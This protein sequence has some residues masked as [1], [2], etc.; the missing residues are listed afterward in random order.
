MS[1]I[2]NDMLGSEAPPS[3]IVGEVSFLE[4]TVTG[5]IYDNYQ[6]FGVIEYTYGNEV[7]EKNIDLEIENMVAQMK[8]Y[9]NRFYR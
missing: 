3:E 7:M 1:W 6:K 8:K 4:N 2:L 9:E 5:T